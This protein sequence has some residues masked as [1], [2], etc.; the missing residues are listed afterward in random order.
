MTEFY[1]DNFGHWEIR[2]EEDVEFYFQVQ[3]ESIWKTCRICGRKVKIRPDYDIC[4]GCAERMEK[5]YEY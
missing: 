4:N 2:D 1:D 5:G 3:K